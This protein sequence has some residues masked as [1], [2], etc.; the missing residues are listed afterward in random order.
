MVFMIDRQVWDFTVGRPA[1]I[2]I[3]MTEAD[4]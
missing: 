2:V 3:R 4:P 1:G